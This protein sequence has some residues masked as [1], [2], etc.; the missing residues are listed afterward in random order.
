[1]MLKTIGR[2]TALHCQVLIIF[3]PKYIPLKHHLL[4]NVLKSCNLDANECLMESTY[5]AMNARCINLPGTYDCACVDGYVKE[6]DGDEYVPNMGCGELIW[7]CF[8]L[9]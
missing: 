6:N 8:W 2:D 1:M 5:C 4:V 3:Y 9:D 7:S